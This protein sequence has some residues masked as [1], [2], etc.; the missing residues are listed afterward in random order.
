MNDCNFGSR[1]GIEKDA[2][3]LCFHSFGKGSWMSPFLGHRMFSGPAVVAGLLFGMAG[4][5]QNV[6]PC[7]AIEGP[8]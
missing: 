1:S 8:H 4:R 2:L 7:G 3:L 5:G 6:L